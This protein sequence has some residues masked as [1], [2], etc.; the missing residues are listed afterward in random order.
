MPR[1]G[2]IIF[3]DLVGKPEMLNVECD[4]CG[5]FDR[6]PQYHRDT[7]VNLVTGPLVNS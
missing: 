3:R 2:A 7:P 5:R 1:K 6:K 4:K